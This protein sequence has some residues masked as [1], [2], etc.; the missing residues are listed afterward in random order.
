MRFNRI[1]LIISE[2]EDRHGVATK[3]VRAV[4]EIRSRL[5]DQLGTPLVGS[6]LLTLDSQTSGI[7]TQ[8]VQRQYNRTV[9][10]ACLMVGVAVNAALAQRL[11]A[12]YISLTATNSLFYKGL[13]DIA[14]V[15][16]QHVDNAVGAECVLLHFRV[17]TAYRVGLAVII[18][19]M[20]L[21]RT[22]RYGLLVA[23]NLLVNVSSNDTV[24]TQAGLVVEYIRTRSRDW[25]FAICLREGKERHAL[26][27]CINGINR[28]V[29]DKDRIHAAC[30]ILQRVAEYTLIAVVL[31]VTP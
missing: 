30:S 13:W 23:V 22:D 7:R 26:C 9:A 14:Y 27:T 20:R 11:F 1:Y 4:M 8:H 16:V 29:Q 19:D 10:T 5:N 31:A 2:I 3:A 6:A 28:H 24:A 25:L 15:Q 21:T 18:P 12:E 17:L